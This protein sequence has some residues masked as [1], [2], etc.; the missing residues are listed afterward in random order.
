MATLCCAHPRICKCF[1]RRRRHQDITFGSLAMDAAS[2]TYNLHC[3]TPSGHLRGFKNDQNDRPTQRS[4][5]FAISLTMLGF[6]RI[7]TTHREQLQ[8][9]NQPRLLIGEPA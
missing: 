1:G 6:Q 8:P 9:R 2:R 3:P 5:I 4:L 7:N